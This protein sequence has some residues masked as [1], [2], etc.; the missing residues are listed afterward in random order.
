MRAI[1]STVASV[2]ASIALLVGCGKAPSAEPPAQSGNE[3]GTCY[4]PS[5]GRIYDTEA[6]CAKHNGTWGRNG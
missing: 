4:H 3:S 2:V 5:D 6:E 1:A